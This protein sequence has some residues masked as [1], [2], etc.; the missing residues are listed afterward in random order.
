MNKLQEL[1]KWY[2]T[3]ANFHKGVE[4]CKKHQIR[5][6]LIDVFQNGATQ[7]NK[8]LLLQI[9]TK[10]IAL[11][12]NPNSTLPSLNNP[13]SDEAKHTSIAKVKENFGMRAKYPELQ[14]N[15]SSDFIKLMFSEALATWD[16]I[17][18]KHDNE[19][20]AAETDEQRFAIMQQLMETVEANDAAHKELRHYN[21]TGEIL[22]KHPKFAEFAPNGKIN[23]EVST[24]YVETEEEWEKEF[25]EMDAKD[26]LMK[27][28]NLRSQISKTKKAIEQN[29][30]NLENNLLPPSGEVPTGKEIDELKTKLTDLELKEQTASAILD[31]I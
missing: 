25:R 10:E 29:L 13:N 6:D 19:L 20:F 9:L 17:I 28:N 21:D 27:R 26:L 5:P 11:L 18:K 3:G 7:G 14:L 30:Y 8:K 31:E 4:L 1:Q 16:E 2:N 23:A 15:E 24:Q 22:G 12:P